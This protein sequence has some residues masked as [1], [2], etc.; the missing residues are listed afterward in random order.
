MR[1]ILL[2][3]ESLSCFSS[4]TRWPTAHGSSSTPELCKTDLPTMPRTWLLLLAALALAAPLGARAGRLDPEA[5]MAAAGA[6]P[7]STA[8]ATAGAA[9]SAM[10]VSMWPCAL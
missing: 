9:S 5:M 2:P 8:A 7:L 6:S 10:A 1:V 4:T 3:T